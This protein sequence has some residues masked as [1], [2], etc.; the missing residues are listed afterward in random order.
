[1]NKYYSIEPDEGSYFVYISNLSKEQILYIT[2][3]IYP[4][5]DIE[6]DNDDENYKYTI[7]APCCYSNSIF[8]NLISYLNNENYKNIDYL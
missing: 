1:M 2:K 4:D 3:N 6:E 8:T 5:Y 7:D